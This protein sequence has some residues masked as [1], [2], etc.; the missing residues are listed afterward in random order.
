MIDGPAPQPMRTGPAEDYVEP[1]LGKKD[2]DRLAVSL[3]A[4]IS[5][6]A[7]ERVRD[8]VDDHVR[9]CFFADKQDVGRRMLG[10]VRTDGTAKHSSAILSFIRAMDKA[11]VAWGRARADPA[12]REQL[13]RYDSQSV[14]GHLSVMDMMGDVQF[15]RIWIRNK[16]NSQPLGVAM[17]PFD[18]LAIRLS[19]IF[20]D[21]TGKQPSCSI[22]RD[23][24]DD[25]P[26]YV[27]FLREID[28]LL[29]PGARRQGADTAGAWAKAAERAIG[30]KDNR[31][32]KIP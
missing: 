8:A 7:R 2:W 29:P 14:P 15:H 16:F 3:G 10:K 4:S 22:A 20:T 28:R 27:A 11:T 30:G 26:P 12:S 19:E 18:R 5:R 32:G 13:D 17:K 9:D 24:S 21:C 6:A 25:L 31:R 23:G 1:A